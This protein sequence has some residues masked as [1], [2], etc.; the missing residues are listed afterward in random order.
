MENLIDAQ[1]LVPKIVRT[2]PALHSDLSVLCSSR[3]LNRISWTIFDHGPHGSGGG[4]DSMVCSNNSLSS[5]DHSLQF[6]DAGAQFSLEEQFPSEDSKIV[7]DFP[8][9]CRGGGDAAAFRLDLTQQVPV[10]VR[11]RSVEYLSLLRS[12]EYLSDVVSGRSLDFAA[13]E[14]T[15]DHESFAPTAES[16]TNRGYVRVQHLRP[17]PTPTV[18]VACQRRAWKTLPSPETNF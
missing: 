15:S 2:A 1:V 12:V 9:P 13:L 7:A 6:F 4:P 3:Q 17:S 16:K 18:R 11:P 5:H 14:R 10:D 8:H